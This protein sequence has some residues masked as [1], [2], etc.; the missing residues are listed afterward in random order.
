MLGWDATTAWSTSLDCFEA[1]SIRNTLTN[2]IDDRAQRGSHRHFDQ[3]SVDDLASE[4][5][6]FGAFAALRAD[7]CEP[8]GPISD[9]GSNV[10]VGLDIIDQCG[11][12][13]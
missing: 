9:D 11:S 3:A 6:D 2:I 12:I 8:F 7:A 10:C 5:E 4:C 1:L 13:P